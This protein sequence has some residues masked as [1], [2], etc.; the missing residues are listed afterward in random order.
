MADTTAA[1][2]ATAGET[3]KDSKTVLFNAQMNDGKTNTRKP[4]KPTASYIQQSNAE[5][6][7]AAHAP[8]VESQTL[9]VITKITISR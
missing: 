1:K 3:S 2:S 6:F 4:L 5:T 9:T 7:S 8:S